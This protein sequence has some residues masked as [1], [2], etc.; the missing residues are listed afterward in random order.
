MCGKGG[1]TALLRPSIQEM[2]ARPPSGIPGALR[3]GRAK[4]VDLDPSGRPA[5][6]GCLGLLAAGVDAHST[7]LSSFCHISSIQELFFRDPPWPPHTPPP[8]ASQRG[9][10]GEGERARGAGRWRR[11]GASSSGPRDVFFYTVNVP[12]SV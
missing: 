3:A 8:P 9:P 10:P 11:E 6:R 1:F 12:S 2:S 4:H 7:S 5:E